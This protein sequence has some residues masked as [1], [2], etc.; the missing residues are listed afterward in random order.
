MLLQ[1][2]RTYRQLYKLAQA[3]PMH[4]LFS[5]SQDSA[6]YDGYAVTVEKE[7]CKYLII[8]NRYFSDEVWNK[9]L[10]SLKS[11]IDTT[12]LDKYGQ[13][14]LY[15]IECPKTKDSYNRFFSYVYG[16]YDDISQKLDNF[17]NSNKKIITPVSNKYR[18]DIKQPLCQFIYAITNESPNFFV[19]ALNQ[20]FSRR[21][22]VWTIR[23]VMMWNEKYGSLSSNLPKKTIT[24]YSD[25]NELIDEMRVIRKYKRV[26]DSINLFNT[27]Q[28]KILKTSDKSDEDIDTLNKF[29]LLNMKKCVNFVRKMS[30]VED[31]NEI[32]DA[33]K[34]LVVVHFR[35]NKES[36]LDYLNNVESLAYNIVKESKMFVVVEILN[37]EAIKR[38]TKSTNWCISKNKKYWNDY[39][40][41]NPDARQF[42]IFDFS[43][44]ENDADSIIGFTIDSSHGITHAHNFFN[45]NLMERNNSV[46]TIVSLINKYNGSVSISDII[47]KYDIDIS[48]IVK[49]DV[50]PF[51][52]NRE[53]MLSFIS[54][55]CDFVTIKDAD[56]KLVVRINGGVMEYIFGERYSNH[57]DEY[58]D[59]CSVIMFAD[60]NKKDEK[61]KRLFIAFIEKDGFEEMPMLVCNEFFHT[62]S[63][64]YFDTLLEEYGLSYDVICRICNNGKRVIDYMCSHNHIMVDKMLSN[65]SIKDDFIKYV[66]QQNGR[67]DD[68]IYDALITEITNV[69]SIDMLNVLYKHGITL[70]DIFVNKQIVR[71]LIC[72][73]VNRFF[74]MTNR[75]PC[76]EE[77]TDFNNGTLSID[78]AYKVALYIITETILNN[79]NNLS[80]F[81][82]LVNN[83]SSYIGRPRQ[84]MFEY[85]LSKILNK[86]KK[87][88]YTNN[89]VQECLLLLCNYPHLLKD[90][91]I[92][93]LAKFSPSTS[94]SSC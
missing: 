10:M 91:R 55:Q 22:S 48:S 79:E 51:E 85:L 27:A 46:G 92:R 38:L 37:Y 33:M 42:V 65:E 73:V 19:W 86:A 20:I 21:V 4:I 64:S 75:I 3:K 25:V 6:I 66:V 43:K 11:I 61:S 7:G 18:L 50:L 54:K 81:E 29:S 36:F 44:N 72:E 89:V 76:D 5:T 28:K 8:Y 31:Y 62:E 13:F 59:N 47:K 35:W 78:N 87:D 23:Q 30:T 16:I 90:E 45:K 41:N 32:M 69:I 40:E 57:F 77:L 60:F 17:I 84:C 58:F 56:N 82:G 88:D 9:R 49:V 83:F 67:N 2:I 74:G 53:S 15:E 14:C 52:F 1:H 93:L 71:S 39:V 80:V 68:R 26:N 94:S 12:L 63:S 70:Y 34:H 24:A